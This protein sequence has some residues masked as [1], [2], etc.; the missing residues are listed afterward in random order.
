VISHQVP[1]L[2]YHDVA[3]TP[4]A[5]FAFYTVSPDSFR[6]Q[7]RFLAWAGYTAVSLDALAGSPLAQDLLPER[8]VVITFD[9]GFRSCIENAVPVLAR[10]GFTATFFIVAGL[11]GDRSRW[12]RETL[13]DDLPLAD[14]RLLRRLVENGFECGA[15]SMS[16]PH[17]PSLSPDACRA[18]LAESKRVLEERL[19]REVPHAAY[20]YGD[21][22]PG[23]RAVA[24]EVGYR[25][26]CAVRGGFSGPDDDR[27]ALRRI[28][29]GG[30]ES[31]VDFVWRLRTAQYP[32]PYLRGKARRA[33]E[34]I[35]GRGRDPE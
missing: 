10:Y 12:L 8:P 3:S 21:F 18:E 1:I 31:L 11:V 23:V 14:W 32:G 30:G 5:G 9:D 15:H 20:P 34:R 6:A 35:G 4:A 26:A 29:V 17:L 13:R 22:T 33:W 28:A 19:G 25:T 7:M 2:M 16:H 24:A 27:F